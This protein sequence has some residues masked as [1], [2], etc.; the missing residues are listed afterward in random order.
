MVPVSRLIVT[1]FSHDG[2]ET[3]APVRLKR[4]CRLAQMCHAYVGS[5]SDV[6]VVT[7]NEIFLVEREGSNESLVQGEELTLIEH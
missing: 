6:V 7:H 1:G 4:T 3:R 2:P 5:L